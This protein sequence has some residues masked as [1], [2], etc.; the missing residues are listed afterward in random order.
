MDKILFGPATIFRPSVAAENAI[1]RLPQER[2]LAQFC[3]GIFP[4]T[5]ANLVLQ[6]LYQAY[7]DYL[8]SIVPEIA[9]RDAA[10]FLLFQYDEAAKILH[11]KGLSRQE[12][13]TLWRS[14]EPNFRRAI[15]YLVELICVRGS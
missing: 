11:G 12:Q 5:P 14:I 10:E 9:S 1:H 7:E 6:C 3:P 8:N 2:L 4:G 15:K 13:L